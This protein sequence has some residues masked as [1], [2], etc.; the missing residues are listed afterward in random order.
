MEV[1]PGQVIYIEKSTPHGFRNLGTT[2]AVIMEVFVK[3]D[4]A[5]ADTGT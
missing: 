1:N 5:A 2:K 4:S 3:A